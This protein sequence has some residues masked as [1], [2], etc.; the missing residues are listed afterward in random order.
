MSVLIIPDDCRTSVKAILFM[1]AL[2]T[3]GG[4]GGKKL[5]EISHSFKIIKERN[6]LYVAP[7][8]SI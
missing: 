4:G 5:L 8:P 7:T 3:S 1:G 6:S 2:T